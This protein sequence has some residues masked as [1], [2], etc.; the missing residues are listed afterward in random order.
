MTIQ[1][2]DPSARGSTTKGNNDTAEASPTRLGVSFFKNGQFGMTMIG[3]EIG[4]KVESS[5]LDTFKTYGPRGLD[6]DD[7]G[8]LIHQLG[9]TDDV[10]ERLDRLAAENDLTFAEAVTFQL[11]M[12]V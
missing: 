7:R 12:S 11:T 1:H 2:F 4:L 9:L 6:E 10:V 8:R 5:V 3:N